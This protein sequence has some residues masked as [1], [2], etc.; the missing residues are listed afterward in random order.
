LHVLREQ[1]GVPSVALPDVV[2]SHT[3]HP[4]RGG[5]EQQRRDHAVNLQLYQ[6]IVNRL[7]AGEHVALNDSAYADWGG[8]VE[9]H[10]L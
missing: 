6:D 5:D 2:A 3:P 9:I 1:H 10:S 8:Y 4:P 7:F